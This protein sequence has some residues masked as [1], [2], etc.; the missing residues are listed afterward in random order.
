ME[1]SFEKEA[2]QFGRAIKRLRELRCLTQEDIVEITYIARSTLAEIEAGKRF[3]RGVTILRLCVAL[4]VSPQLLAKFAFAKWRFKVLPLESPY[5][6]HATLK[7]T[8]PSSPLSD[9][10]HAASGDGSHPGEAANFVRSMRTE[11]D[12]GGT[13]CIIVIQNLMRIVLKTTSKCFKRKYFKS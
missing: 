4:K 13:E 9:G 2:V 1:D 3:P 12:R 5:D 11:L 6:K 8:N 7:N 10:A